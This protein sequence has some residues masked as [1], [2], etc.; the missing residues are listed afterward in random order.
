MKWWECSIALQNV[1]VQ[2]DRWLGDFNCDSAQTISDWWGGFMWTMSLPGDLV[3]AKIAPTS[4]GQFLELGGGPFAGTVFGVVTGIIL[5]MI[6]LGL[7][8][9]FLGMAND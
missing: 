6:A 8:G 2:R 3:V 9:S 1:G 7:I 4:L 5:T